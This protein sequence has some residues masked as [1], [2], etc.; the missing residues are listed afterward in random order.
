MEGEGIPG[1]E[2]GGGARLVVHMAFEKDVDE[3]AWS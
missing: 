1:D 2:T 3:L